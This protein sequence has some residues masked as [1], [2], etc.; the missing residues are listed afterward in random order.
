MRRHRFLI[1][2]V[3]L[4]AALV[5]SAFARQLEAR[6]P[7]YP[8]F[9][10]PARFP[11]R[12]WKIETLP[13][14]EAEKKLLEADTALSRRYTSPTNPADWTELSII[15]GHRKK[16]VHNPAFCI[17]G[18]GWETVSEETVTYTEG[19]KTVEA[20]RARIVKDGKSLF[21]TYFFTD[22]TFSCA[23]MGRFQWEQMISRLKSKRSLG[24]L[25]RVLTP[26]GANA[27]AGSALSD[28]F[29]SSVLPQAL[30]YLQRAK[31]SAAFP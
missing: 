24:A 14:S 28:D 11:Y 8:D 7:G 18:D 5:G 2:N 21:A 26:A 20:I 9:L 3:L 22:G 15:A 29:C 17:G 23:G 13:I 4:F 10:N 25:I 1:V 16:T 6:Q 19:G 12:N 31:D 30:A 27:E